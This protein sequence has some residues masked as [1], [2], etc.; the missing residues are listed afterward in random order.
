MSLVAI[1]AALQARGPIRYTPITQSYAPVVE[2]SRAVLRA[3]PTLSGADGH[4]QVWGVLLDMAELWEL[5]VFHVLRGAMPEPA[6]TTT[7]DPLRRRDTCFET[8]LAPDS[9]RSSPT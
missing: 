7:G 4:Q 9:P 3:R 8:R 2:L 1:E 6:V 5:Y